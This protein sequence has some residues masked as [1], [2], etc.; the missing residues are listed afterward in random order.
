M[1][2]SIQKIFLFTI[3]LLFCVLGCTRDHGDISMLD[4]HAVSMET[5]EPVDV[6][7]AFAQ[8]LLPIL[9][10]RCALSGCHVADGPHGLD[11]RTYESFV[12]G[13]EHG[14]V[15][16]P[17][18][19]EDS[20]VVEE[21]VSGRM[22]PP[23]RDPLSAAEIQLFI[24]W[25]NQQEVQDG[26]IKHAHSDEHAVET[27]IDEDMDDEHDDDDDAHDGM[28]DDDGHADDEE[29]DKG[30][31]D[32]DDAHDDHEDNGHDDDDDN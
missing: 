16:I 6:E 23:P 8:N 32:D 30:H 14:A 21:I 4:D 15:F 31:D 7:V 1:A 28:D 18:N 2:T 27:L 12:R 22:P 29:E 25:I 19:A 13:G 9:T 20:A 10:E 26:V 17:G 5:H 11:F 3:G 24:E